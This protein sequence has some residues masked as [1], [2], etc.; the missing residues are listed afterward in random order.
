MRNARYVNRAMT[1][2][3]VAFDMATLLMWH[4]EVWEVIMQNAFSI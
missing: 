2:E 1:L 3:N 4:I